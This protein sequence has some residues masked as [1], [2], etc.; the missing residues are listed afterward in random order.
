MLFGLGCWV[1]SGWVP[2]VGSLASS[3]DLRLLA[4]TSRRNVREVSAG[5]ESGG[6]GEPL[7]AA[8]MLR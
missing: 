7:A 2:L 6:D 5:E 4:H 8:A 1:G 3:A